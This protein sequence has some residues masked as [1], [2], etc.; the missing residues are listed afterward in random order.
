MAGLSKRFTLAAA[1]AAALVVVAAACGSDAKPASQG[2]PAAS[3]ATARPAINRDAAPAFEVA[4]V[5]GWINS[6]PLTIQG[7]IKANKVVLVDFWT[8][9]CVN[10]IRT[11]PFLREWNA[12]Y[13][14]RGLVILG[15]HTPEFDFEK[16]RA[17]VE[18]ATSENGIVWPIAQDNDYGTWRAFGNSYWPAKYLIGADGKL[19]FSHFGEGSYIETEQK[20][21]AALKAAGYKVDDIPLGSVDELMPDKNATSMTREM[22]AGYER[23]FAYGGEYAGQDA[24]Y[25]GPDRVT[26]YVDAGDHAH[27]KF[28]LQGS[29]KNEKQAI[30]HTRQ[31]ESPDDYIALKFA[32]TSVNVVVEPRGPEPFDVLVEMDGAPLTKEEAGTDVQFDAQGRS[33]ITVTD[34]RLYAVVRLPGF[35]ISELKL[36]AASQNFAVSAFTFGIYESGI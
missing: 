26:N 30:V 14:D 20:I 28:Y 34:A 27:N 17:N 8:Y 25:A 35:A 22:Y 36:R 7:L 31:T 29:W 12:K 1:A 9:T 11:F 21:R 24:Y 15:V 18:K 13:A 6:E 3:T 5:S 33:F 16:V 4:G 10:C 19:A 32:A 23:N 2:S